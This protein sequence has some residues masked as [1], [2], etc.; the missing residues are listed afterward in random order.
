MLRSFQNSGPTSGANWEA[1][2]KAAYEEL[3]LH[4]HEMSPY[5]HNLI[6]REIKRRQ[7]ELIPI[8]GAKVI[9]EFKAAIKAYQ[10]AEAGVDKARTA[11]INR[12]DSAKLNTELQL[13][14]ARVDLAYQKD[15]NPHRG[16]DTPAS[17]RLAEIFAE[18]VHSDDL[19]K[20]RA[21]VEVFKAIRLPA[22]PQE[23]RILVNQLAKDAEAAE[24]GL[25]DTAELHQARQNR[26]EALDKLGAKREHLDKVSRL[27]GMGGIDD[28]LSPGPFAKA[29]RMVQRVNGELR[30]YEEDAPEVTGVYWKE[31]QPPPPPPG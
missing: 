16:A 25:R 28:A 3:R 27:L 1:E 29:A 18:A 5:E 14:Q 9:G 30:I 21:A 23:E 7:D 4:G 15:V 17:K 24:P 10:D 13:L 2:I 11:E 8:V 22:G 31:P 12:F 6:S 20:Q 26:T 19:H